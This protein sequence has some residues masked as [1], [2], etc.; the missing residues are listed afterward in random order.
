MKFFT[1]GFTLVELLVV[2][3]IMA[4]VGVVGLANYGSFGDSQQL[5]NSSLD[6][7]SLI[8]EAQTNASTGF[9]CSSDGGGNKAV[10]WV[11]FYK[12]PVS[13][14]KKI[15]INCDNDPLAGSSQFVKNYK[16]PL[17]IIVNSISGIP[18][19]S[20]TYPNTWVKIVFQPLSGKVSLTAQGGGCASAQ[21]LNINLMNT[22]TGNTN[23][24]TI[25]KGGAVSVY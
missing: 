21:S 14:I 19:C 12:E 11:W 25:N 7:Q 2:V 24:V 3:A 1:Q 8:K 4:M 17:N 13:N 22:K 6:I 15:T 9:F 16:L 18:T 20:T 5:K 10:W 23:T